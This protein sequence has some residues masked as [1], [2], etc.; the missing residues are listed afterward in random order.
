MLTNDLLTD[1]E[2]TALT[3]VKP[4]AHG[5]SEKIIQILRAAGIYH[6]LRYDG[7]VATTWTHVHKAGEGTP[8]GEGSRKKPNFNAVNRAA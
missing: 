8:S 6:W 2:L 1:D 7:T 5:R 4:G 3:G